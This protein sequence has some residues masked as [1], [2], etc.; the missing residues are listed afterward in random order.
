MIQDEDP[1]FQK[2]IINLHGKGQSLYLKGPI[3]KRKNNNNNKT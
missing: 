1:C 2:F 3:I